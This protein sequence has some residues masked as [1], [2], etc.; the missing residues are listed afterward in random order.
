MIQVLCFECRLSSGFVSLKGSAFG[1]IREH[2]MAKVKSVDSC[3]F[4]DE[5]S[6]A[7][8]QIISENTDAEPV[9]R[10]KYK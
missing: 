8:N 10:P 2:T 1:P 7:T 9:Q 4:I 6:L 3:V 5:D